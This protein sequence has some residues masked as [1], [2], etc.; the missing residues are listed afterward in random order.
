MTRRGKLDLDQRRWT[1][2][3][4]AGRWTGRRCEASSEAVGPERAE[5]VEVAFGGKS[6]V[7]AVRGGDL[8]A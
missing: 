7:V 5:V 1:L 8:K 4:K 3:W 2:S 6:R